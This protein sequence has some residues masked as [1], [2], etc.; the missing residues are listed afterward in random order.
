MSS[1]QIVQKK[2]AET[3]PLVDT[4]LLRSLRQSQTE[5]DFYLGIVALTGAREPDI[6]RPTLKMPW[7]NG[8]YTTSEGLRNPDRIDYHVKREKPEIRLQT[9]STPAY[10]KI[11]S[12]TPVLANT[13]D[14]EANQL[15]NN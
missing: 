15:I 2:K 1:I 4:V 7:G 5:V 6:F 11:Y 9:T 14:Q 12:L 13:S 10:C 3:P 8:Y